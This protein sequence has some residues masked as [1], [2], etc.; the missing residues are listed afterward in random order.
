MLW[1]GELLR[2]GELAA[3]LA[4]TDADA[5]FGVLAPCRQALEQHMRQLNGFGGAMAP[6]WPSLNYAS[7]EVGASAAAAVH[8]QQQWGAAPLMPHPSPTSKPVELQVDAFWP[9]PTEKLGQRIKT[10][11][12][13]PDRIRRDVLAGR[14]GLGALIGPG[15]T[16]ITALQ[17]ETSC[18]V[19]MTEH[20]PPGAH[21]DDRLV[22]IVG[23]AAN[24][25]VAL[26]RVLQ[27]LSNWKPNSKRARV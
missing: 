10:A 4:A 5:V 11:I 12:E 24:A 2:I 1:Q 23:T 14:H 16:I 19:F 3:H 22:V 20:P 15:G 25:A 21:E 27:I 6:Q 17:A 26:D 9:P 18:N 7:P 13:K 8:G